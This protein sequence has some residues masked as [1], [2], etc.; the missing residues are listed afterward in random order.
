[1][2]RILLAEDDEIM[3][4][5]LFDR[6][7]KNGWQVDDAKDGKKALSLVEENYYNL[8]LSDI[9]MPGLD[10]T[11]LLDKILRVSPDTDDRAAW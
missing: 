3:R 9:G 1:M 11:H 4:E 2:S 7:T 10:V 6:L 5:T 8:V